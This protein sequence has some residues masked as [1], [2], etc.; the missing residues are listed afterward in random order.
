MVSIRLIGF[1]FAGALAPAFAH[2]AD[3]SPYFQ[4]YDGQY[5][6]HLMVGSASSSAL[7]D[8]EKAL[9]EGNAAVVIPTAAAGSALDKGLQIPLSAEA[10]KSLEAVKA[11][12]KN[13]I[14][15]IP[16]A[17]G[18]TVMAGGAQIMPPSACILAKSV[19]LDSSLVLARSCARANWLR[20]NLG[21]DSMN[22]G[23]GYVLLRRPPA[24]MRCGSWT[25]MTAAEVA[26]ANAR[27]Q[28]E[29]T[30]AA[31]AKREQDAARLFQAGGSAAAQAQALGA[32]RPR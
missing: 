32:A 12:A 13:T 6:A 15:F 27:H 24:E 26:A 25:V 7:S 9:L 23:A 28:Q 18:R 22:L 1:A 31:Q 8:E 5:Q 4:I 20:R 2:A 29:S 3:A 21:G 14:C 19:R 10:S 11:E 16:Q 17:Q 30:A